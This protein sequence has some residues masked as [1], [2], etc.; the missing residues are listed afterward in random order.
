VVIENARH[1]RIGGK[2][3]RDE[4]FFDCYHNS[5]PCFCLFNTN[6]KAKA[7]KAALFQPFL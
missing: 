4:N 6:A 5:P 3:C 7:G 1:S 2:I